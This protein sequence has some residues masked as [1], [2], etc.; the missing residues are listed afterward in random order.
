[1]AKNAGGSLERHFFL[2]SRGF[3]ADGSA[4]HGA[5]VNMSS[6]NGIDGGNGNPH[7]AA[8]KAGIVGFT[9]AVAKDV[10]V[11]G[12]RVN[13]VA[14]GFIDTPLRESISPANQRAQIAA[15]PIG[16]A[17][18]QTKSHKQFYF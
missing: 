18:Q 14:P 10:I 3:E 6:I 15:T 7:Y 13:A 12:I 1:M 9:R 11:Q 8:A 2:H 5:I 17:A 4:G 16:R